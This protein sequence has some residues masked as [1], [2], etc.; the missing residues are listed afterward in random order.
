MLIKYILKMGKCATC[1]RDGA[2]DHKAMGYERKKAKAK[3]KAN[4]NCIDPSGL[5]KSSHSNG[6]VDMSFGN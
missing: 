5:E 3:N 1:C 2:D 4:L 6:S